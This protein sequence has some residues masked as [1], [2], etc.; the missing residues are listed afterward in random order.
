M[1]KKTITLTS[2]IFFLFFTEIVFGQNSGGESSKVKTFVLGVIEEIQS[3][4]L[5]EK[6]ILNIYLPKGYNN[7]DTIKYPVVYLPDGSAV[8]DFIHKH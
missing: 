6:R 8:E 7:N 3:A 5:S 1:I 4:E 2:I